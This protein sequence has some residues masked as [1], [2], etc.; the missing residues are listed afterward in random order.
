MGYRRSPNF[1]W[2]VLL[3]F[4]FGPLM[5]FGQYFMLFPLL[6]LAVLGFVGITFAQALS[7]RWNQPLPPQQ[8]TKPLE[9]RIAYLEALIE[10]L[11]REQRRLQQTVDW[12]GRLLEKESLP[13]KEENALSRPPTAPS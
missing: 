9:R 12:Q 4:L 8:D 1:F 13:P 7:S 3:I 11:T 10:D 6:M 2:I 5:G